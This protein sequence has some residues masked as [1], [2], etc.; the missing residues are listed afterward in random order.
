MYKGAETYVHIIVKLLAN[1]FAAAH[2]GA[3]ATREY[4]AYAAPYQGFNVSFIIG[5]F[6]QF[7]L[8][9]NPIAGSI[10]VF[11]AHGQSVAVV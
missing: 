5:L 1:L 2:Q 11:G 6:A 8:P 4:L 9:E 3:A 7:I 10:L